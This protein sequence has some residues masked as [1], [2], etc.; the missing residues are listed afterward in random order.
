MKIIDWQKFSGS[1]HCEEGLALFAT[2]EIKTYKEFEKYFL[3]Y[4][5]DV[6]NEV[7]KLKNS[8]IGIEKAR[9]LARRAFKRFSGQSITEAYGI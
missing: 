9:R 7:R 4:M 5:E 2:G 3:P 8:K 6:S 1:S